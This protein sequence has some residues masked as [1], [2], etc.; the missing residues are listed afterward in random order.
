MACRAGNCPAWPLLG[1]SSGVWRLSGNG[2]AVGWAGEGLAAAGCALPA[3][4]VAVRHVCG[5]L[6]EGEAGIAIQPV[7]LS[8]ASLLQD[9]ALLEVVFAALDTLGSAAVESVAAAY[10]ATGDSSNDASA[11]PATD[12]AAVVERVSQAVEAFRTVMPPNSNP[13]SGQWRDVLTAARRLAATLLDW[14]RR[15]G[16]QQE[17]QLEAA[18]AAAA[19]SCAYLRC[20]NL[21]G[22]GGP[23]AGQGEGSQRCR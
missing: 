6:G 12:D 3:Q 19:R 18:Q 4:V 13:S 20:A 16:A 9:D 17:Q 14:W 10:E 1:R 8:S 11:T 21:G 7:L 15:P 5:V 23:A 2:C 22:G